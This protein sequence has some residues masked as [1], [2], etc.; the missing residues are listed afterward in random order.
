MNDDMSIVLR[1]GY[2]SSWWNGQAVDSSRCLDA[3]DRRS[4]IPQVPYFDR[5][6]VR[7]RHNLLWFAKTGAH[8]SFSVSLNKGKNPNSKIFVMIFNRS[9]AITWNTETEWIV[10]RKSHNLNVESI[11]QV[12][13]NLWVG[14]QATWV[15]SRSLQLTSN[16]YTFMQKMKNSWIPIGKQNLLASQW[17]KKRSGFHIVQIG[18]SIPTGCDTQFVV[19]PLTSTITKGAMYVVQINKL[20]YLFYLTTPWW[21]DKA[22]IGT[23][24]VLTIADLESLRF[25]IASVSSDSESGDSSLEPPPK[26]CDNLSGTTAA[27]QI[28]AVPSPLAV[29][30]KSCVGWNAIE[31]TEPVCPT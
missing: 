13:T 18:S 12:A 7:P 4:H 16:E 27:F 23:L 24:I 29:K 6:I 14:W 22:M 8:H 21:P 26:A 9:N 5:P 20:G 19:Q 1:N 28:W 30:A 11:L 15:N 3:R 2:H 25:P 10:S 31:F 17:L